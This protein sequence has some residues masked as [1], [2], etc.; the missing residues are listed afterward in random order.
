MI[1]NIRVTPNA[2][3]NEITKDGNSL[4]VRLNAPAAEGKANSALIELLAEHFGVKKGA[5]R[6]IS[7]IKS[8][9]KVVE[10]K[11]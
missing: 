4:R 7:G 10:I 5:V 6:I 2:K 9:N 1:L 8:R 11:K 3:K